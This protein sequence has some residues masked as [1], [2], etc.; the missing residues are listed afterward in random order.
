MTAPP[1]SLADR[2]H[3]R[4]AHDILTRRLAGGETLVEGRLAETMGVSRTPMREAL[5]RL[6]GE[7]LLVRQGSGGFAVRQVSVHEFFH[8]LRVRVMLEPEAA[9]AAARSQAPPVH[10]I[11]ALR[12]RI[13]HLSDAERQASPHWDADDSLHRLVATMA[14]NPVLA[15]IIESLRQTTRLLEMLRPFD[16]V[17]DDA[18]EHTQILLA[19]EAGEADTAAR[20]MAAHLKSVEQ[21]VLQRLVT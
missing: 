3:D 10:E 4:L 18:R 13:G 5:S 21:F 1:Q 9:R 7:G 2:A 15:R 12:A 16:R 6:E 11:A 8:A 19:L 17:A 14:G 20:A